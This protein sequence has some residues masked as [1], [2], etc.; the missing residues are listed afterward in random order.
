MLRVNGENMEFEKMNLMDLVKSRNFNPER[1][2]V[3][4]NG[5]IVKRGTYEEIDLTDGDKVE[6]VCFV[7][8]G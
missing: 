8:G 3:E 4:L 1:I 2:A 5:N 7:G 6:I